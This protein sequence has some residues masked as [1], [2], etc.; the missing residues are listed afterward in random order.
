MIRQKRTFTRFT[1]RLTLKE[2]H[3]TIARKTQFT[4][5]SINLF[6]RYFMINEQLHGFISNPSCVQTNKN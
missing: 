3:I 1:S 2:S 6:V 5:V 4:A